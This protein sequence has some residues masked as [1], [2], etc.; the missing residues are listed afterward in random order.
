[1]ELDEVKDQLR[2][3]VNNRLNPY[4]GSVIFVWIITNKTLLFGL[5]N[6]SDNY[7]LQQ[8]IDWVHLQLNSF[9]CLSWL[10]GF[11]GF[12]AT[13]V[14]ALFW[15]FIMMILFNKINAFG[16]GLYIYI[17]KGSIRLLQK[18]DDGNWIPKMD[19]EKLE[20]KHIKIEEE[21]TQKRADLQ[22]VQIKLESNA[23]LNSSLKKDLEKKENEIKDSNIKFSQLDKQ[24]FE[25]SEK[26]K[27]LEK[28]L[29]DFEN[30]KKAF[31]IENA[32]YGIDNKYIEVTSI[33]KNAFSNGDPL[34]IENSVF[35]FDPNKFSVKE[36]VIEYSY[37]NQKKRGKYL[38]GQIIELKDGIIVNSETEKSK[39]NKEIL[40]NLNRLAIIFY[41]AWELTYAKDNVMKK[42]KIEIS[43]SGYYYIDGEVTFKLLVKYINNSAFKLI[44]INKDNA[45]HSTES[46]QI[47]S[48]TRISGT[49]SLG[50][51]L[52]Y[53][54][55]LL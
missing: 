34:A 52:E 55:N 20:R 19:Y 13:I 15:G 2:N 41:G 18:I 47:I 11:K 40:E 49:D 12:Y 9:T 6:F 5:F 39:Q 30:E 14:W 24:L 33:I 44:K 28:E 43:S 48:K 54:K 7:S 35:K 32:V 16:K 25:K 8:K 53:N 36:L 23:A 4:F 46:L 45:I 1:M 38:E 37:L 42:E 21:V 27:T 50:Y 22:E 29:N 3:Y 17:N 51:S 26:I 31:K 10:F